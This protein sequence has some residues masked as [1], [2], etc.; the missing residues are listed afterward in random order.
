MD[1]CILWI[2]QEFVLPNIDT[3]FERFANWLIFYAVWNY[4]YYCVDNSNRGNIMGYW[5]NT[6]KTIGRTNVL[7]F[8][9]I[10][11]YLAYEHWRFFE[12]RTTYSC[13]FSRSSGILGRDAITRSCSFIWL[14]LRGSSSRTFPKCYRPRT[15]NVYVLFD[16]IS[17]RYVAVHFSDTGQSSNREHVQ[18]ECRRSDCVLKGEWLGR[19][20]G[21]PSE[22]TSVQKYKYYILLS[23][24]VR[25]PTD[26]ARERTRRRA[27]T[28]S[29]DCNVADFQRILP[30]W[31]AQEA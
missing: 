11:R 29:Y 9:F 22:G 19:F 14:E 31:I 20:C 27:T 28:K 13:L 16:N 12:W 8:S 30:W 25:I 6:F 10:R 23:G 2:F 1:F 15:F 18:N 3:H 21:R 4:S 26:H 24:S 17:R 5:R 7:G